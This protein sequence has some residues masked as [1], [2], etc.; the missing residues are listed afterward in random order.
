M[1]HQKKCG[2]KVEE[3]NFQLYVSFQIAI[4]EVEKYGSLRGEL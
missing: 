1:L 3:L 2:Y 4:A